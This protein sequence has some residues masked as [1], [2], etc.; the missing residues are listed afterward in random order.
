M[1]KLPYRAMLPILR[2]ILSLPIVDENEMKPPKE[3][4]NKFKKLILQEFNEEL[5]DDEAYERFDRLDSVLRV[6]SKVKFD[7][8]KDGH[9]IGPVNQ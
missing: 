4:I 8:A 3:V 2:L 5:T 9:T 7:K 6:V 1:A